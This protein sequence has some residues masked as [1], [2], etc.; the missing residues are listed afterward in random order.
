M[1]SPEDD[2][3]DEVRALLSEYK[4]F[5]SGKAL[6][7]WAGCPGDKNPVYPCGK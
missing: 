3:S 6:G 1:T 5:L 7:Y 2:A 4:Q